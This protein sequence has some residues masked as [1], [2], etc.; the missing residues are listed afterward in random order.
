ML[1]AFRNYADDGTLSGGSWAST[2]PLSNLQDRQL[3]AIARS[4]NAAVAN[5]A[6]DCDFGQGRT[7]SFVALLKHNL[8]QSGQWRVRLGD[9]P[10]FAASLYDSGRVDIWPTTYPFG[11]GLWGEFLWGGKLTTAE[12]STYGISGY[13]V[14]PLPVFARHL[15]IELFDAANAAG[16]V[17]AGRLIAGPAWQPAINL[18]YGWHLAQVDESRKTRSRGG[19]TYV[20]AM[21]RFRRLTFDLAHM[22][23]DEAWGYAYEL[24][25]IKGVGGDLLVMIDPAKTTHLHRQTVYGSLTESAPISNPQFGL[26]SKPFTVEELL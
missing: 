1:I 2:L 24:D 22:R 11:V 18:Q 14:L 26:F 3:S 15:K 17:Q 6:V 10:A 4:T 7:I 12:A 13:V 5:T 20:D 23:E 19:Q 25:R 21:P 8:G 9:D 16:Y